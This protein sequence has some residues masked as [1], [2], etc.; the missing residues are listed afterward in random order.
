LEG[1]RGIDL[2]GVGIEKEADHNVGLIEFLDNGAKGLDLVCGVESAFCG[3][4]GTIFGNEAYFG[5]LKAEGEFE[6]CR[7]GSHFEVEFLATFTA[8]LEDVGILNMT[9]IFAEMDCD[10]VRACIKTSTSQGYGIGF[11]NDTGKGVA[12]SRLPESGKVINVYTQSDHSCIL[13]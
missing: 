5:G 13:S 3:D 11:R 9:T 6:H 2:A 1:C 8:E 4:F 12:V 7:G 10:G